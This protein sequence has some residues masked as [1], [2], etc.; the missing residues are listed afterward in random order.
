MTRAAFDYEADQGS[1]YVGAPETVARR[2]ATTAK[3]LGISRFHNTALGM[4]SHKK[5]MRCIELY[6]RKVIPLTRDMLA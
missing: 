1:L 3:A 2:I 6:G 4:L 5:I